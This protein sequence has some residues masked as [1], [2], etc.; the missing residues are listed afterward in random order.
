MSSRRTTPAGAR[1]RAAAAVGRLAGAASRAT[2]RGQGNTLPG[3]VAERLAPGVARRRAARLDRVALVSGT[4]GKTTT[5]AMLAAAL[6]ADGRRVV[7]NQTGSNLHRGLATALLR[8][9]ST[10]Q[11]A[12]LE[13]DEAVLPRAVEELRPRLLVLL[14]LT[15]DQLD[16]HHEVGGMT[17]RWRAAVAR[18]DRAAEVVAGGADPRTAWVA[19]AAPHALLVAPAHARLGRDDAGCPRCGGLLREQPPGPYR[20]NRCGWAPAPAAVVVERDGHDVHL[21]GLGQRR[22]TR[23]PVA[24]DGYALDAAM[25]WTAALR[26]G[27]DPLRA[28]AAIAWLEAVQD[29]YASG[30]SDGTPVRLL[31]AKNP[32]GWDEALAAATDR[33]RAAV[34]SVNG[35]GPDGRDTSWLWDVD[36]GALRGRPQV[37][38]TGD[39]AEDVAVR[40]QVAG[41]ACSLVRPLGRAIAKAGGRGREVDLFAD[42]TSFQLARELIHRR[43]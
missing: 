32:A 7:S 25:A 12:V 9:D 10:A 11:D 4:N 6:A 3:L 19:Q 26:L 24:T 35:G 22:A 42:Y 2:R 15:R 33:G 41:V 28:L 39:R 36:L 38:A 27:A 18:L 20:C 16:R 17:R 40:L 31:L 34:V 14:N 29:R 23:L 13:V 8:A 5:T 37:V 30:S 21:R 1:D 43:G